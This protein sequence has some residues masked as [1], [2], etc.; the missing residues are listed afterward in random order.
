MSGQSA[1]APEP[2]DRDRPAAASLSPVAAAGPQP[3]GRLAGKVVVVTGSET[4][5]GRAMAVRC[6][7]DGAAVVVVGVKL[8]RPTT[9]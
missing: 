5:I 3:S 7:G 8:T 9:R 2:A 1:Q 4:G 6:A